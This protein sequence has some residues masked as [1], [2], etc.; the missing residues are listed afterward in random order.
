M[1]VGILVHRRTGRDDVIICI[2]FTQFR[3]RIP[4]R[5]YRPLT[6]CLAFDDFTFKLAM[7]RS[8]TRY[9]ETGGAQ[10]GDRQ[11]SGVTTGTALV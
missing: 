9:L 6:T 11:R 10:V 4:H 1:I 3:G 7:K 5:K 8:V 2:S